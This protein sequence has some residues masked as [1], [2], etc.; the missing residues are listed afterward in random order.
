MTRPTL[1]EILDA[2]AATVKCYGMY[3]SSHGHGHTDSVYFSFLKDCM[4]TNLRLFSADAGIM[5]RES[6]T[7]NRRNK[8]FKYSNYSCLIDIIQDAIAYGYTTITT[9]YVAM[10]TARPAWTAGIMNVAIGT[11][12]QLTFRKRNGVIYF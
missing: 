11:K 12:K 5:C 6:G 10:T 1:D 3:P 2:I 7:D 8:L 4:P 9:P